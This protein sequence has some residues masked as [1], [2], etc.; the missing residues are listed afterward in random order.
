VGTPDC[1]PGGQSFDTNL[2]LF[3]A[4]IIA[5]GGRDLHNTT[6]G[7][8]PQ[9]GEVGTKIFTVL[10]E[11]NAEV[12]QARHVIQPPANTTLL[13]I[14]MSAADDGLNDFDLFV[15]AGDEPTTTDFDCRQNGVGQFAFCHFR[16]PAP[17]PWHILVQHVTGAGPY[18]VVATTFDGSKAPVLCHGVAATIVGTEADDIL[19]GTPEDDVIAGLG[20]NDMIDG[21]EGDDV[22]CGGPGD[23]V[24]EGGPGHDRLFGNEGDD[25]LRGGEGN[26]RLV[27]GAGNDRLVGGP[28][29]DILYG[30]GGDDVLVCG[31][32]IDIADGGEGTNTVSPSC[33]AV[34]PSP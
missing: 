2:F 25:V 10:G 13:R 26:D 19:L 17:G 29:D 23:D 31:S 27:G 4:W 32:G 28:G 24:L 16:N 30:G 5:Q 14:T 9:V 22:I 21:L 1:L 6:C 34:V 11:L 18:Q 12:R 7:S 33:E 15:K 20:G 8:L 3:R